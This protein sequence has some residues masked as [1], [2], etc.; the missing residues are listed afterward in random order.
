MTI[1]VLIKKNQELRAKF[2]GLRFIREFFP[3]EYARL[4]GNLILDD[5]SLFKLDRLAIEQAVNRSNLFSLF[6]SLL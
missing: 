3:E 5:D 1:D 2:S 6:R 4:E